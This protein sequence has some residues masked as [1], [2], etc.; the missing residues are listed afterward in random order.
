MGWTQRAAQGRIMLVADHPETLGLKR[1]ES[2]SKSYP[3]LRNFIQAQGRPDFLAETD[4]DRQRYLVLYYL[5]E[6]VAYAAR[7]RKS[8]N[9]AMEF[10]RPHPITKG[11]VE[12][13]GNLREKH[14]AS[15]QP[16]R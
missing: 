7:I 1:I 4:S 8:R 10:T 2:Q 14:G 11:E 6:K 12:L 13:L 5:D 9:H 16:V 15:T 3:D